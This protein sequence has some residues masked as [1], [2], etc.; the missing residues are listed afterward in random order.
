MKFKKI[1][2]LFLILVMSISMT[3]CFKSDTM[4]DIDIYTIICLFIF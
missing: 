4:E 2:S 3:G 1:I